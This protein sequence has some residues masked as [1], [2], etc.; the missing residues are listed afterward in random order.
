[1]AAA[2]WAAR[3]AQE[4]GRI[5]PQV[6]WADREGSR[7]EGVRLAAKIAAARTRMTDEKG[8]SCGATNCGKCAMDRV[9]GVICRG[10]RG[11]ASVSIGVRRLVPR[12]HK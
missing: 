9:C 7:A 3:V 6:A 5:P 1:M 10:K 4:K 12:V 8:D 11:E 2:H